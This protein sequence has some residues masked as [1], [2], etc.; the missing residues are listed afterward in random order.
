MN[1]KAEYYF[2]LA[3]DDFK[4]KD[5]EGSFNNLNRAIEL[6]PNNIIYYWTRGMRRAHLE[7]YDLAVPDFTKVIEFGSDL[8]DIA[9]A[10]LQRATCYE[11][12]QQREKLLS[13]LDWLIKHGKGDSHIYAWRADCHRRLNHL[14]EAIED[15]SAAIQLAPENDEL[16]LQRARTAYAIELYD[17][18]IIDLTQIL[19]LGKPH[20]NFLAAV[21]RWR[22]NAN[23]KM[24]K[25]EEAF[26]DFSQMSIMYGLSPFANVADYLS[27][28]SL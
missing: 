27:D 8:E 3:E 17:E 21:Y 7:D 24:N 16:L 5:L 28:Y 10:Y 12:L 20:H 22:A 26:Q 14:R 11:L 13:D 6:D 23:Y 18:A 2:N 25:L 15:F 1:Q 19:V 9:A 4:T